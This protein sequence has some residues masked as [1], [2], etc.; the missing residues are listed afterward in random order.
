M[1]DV[2]T[3]LGREACE[4][5]YPWFTIRQRLRVELGRTSTEADTEEPIR[6][7]LWSVAAVAEVVETSTELL[8]SRANTGDKAELYEWTELLEV[9]HFGAGHWLRKGKARDAAVTA[10]EQVATFVELLVEEPTSDGQQIISVATVEP[11]SE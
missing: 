9:E 4:R 10:C 6:Q 1:S 7:P 8:V 11:D 2:A 5:V 3:P